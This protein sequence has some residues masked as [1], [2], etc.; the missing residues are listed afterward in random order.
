MEIPPLQLGNGCSEAY[1]D[2]R[3]YL[4]FLQ[5]PLP[6]ETERS[7]AFWNARLHHEV[8]HW[9]RMLGTTFGHF[10]LL[11]RLAR[12]TTLWEAFEAL[13]PE[14]LA[15]VRKHRENGELIWSVE[16]PYNPGLAGENFGLFGQFWGEMVLATTSLMDGMTDWVD[17]T[18]RDEIMRLALADTWLHAARAQPQKYAPYPTKHKRAR[19]WLVGRCVDETYV[20]PPRGGGRPQHG[21]NLTSRLLLECASTIDE[22]LL[23][24]KEK[25]ETWE[26]VRKFNRRKLE[27]TLYG[28]P[29][30]VARDI[31]GPHVSLHTILALIDW[32]LNP[33]LPMLQPSL[34]WAW[35]REF[36]PPA[37]FIDAAEMVAKDSRLEVFGSASDGYRA[38]RD[39]LRA[40][41]L[42][43]GEVEV[44]LQPNLA[45][46]FPGV[47]TGLDAFYIPLLMASSTLLAQRE[48]NPD[49]IVSPRTYIA[50]QMDNPE[51]P[52][53]ENERFARWL[54]AFYPFVT[55]HSDELECGPGVH[56]EKARTFIEAS[57]AAT[58]LE[59]IVNETAAMGDQGLGRS[60]D[61]T[62]MLKS[63][64]DVAGDLTGIRL[65]ASPTG[66]TSGDRL[67]S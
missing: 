67:G 50:R 49:L 16:P 30:S 24:G 9:R 23:E 7:I 6:A 19:S 58:A 32:A 59:T 14:Q 45:V 54:T 40:A 2:L 31:I 27:R 3:T 13:T 26:S 53:G 55:V 62:Q 15:A 18:A 43:Y 44:D 57:L 36:Y 52:E 65:R 48:E 38:F 21:Y 64:T 56:P 5:E 42:R 34:D 61:T 25:T 4:L 41:G 11:Q 63:A 46:H 22:V 60:I 37:R 12:D 17:G 39:G 1:L 28:V 35:W 8:G 20:M 33:P 66:R 51:D 10:I 29:A 47:A